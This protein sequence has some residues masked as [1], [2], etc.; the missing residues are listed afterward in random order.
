MSDYPDSVG[1]MWPVDAEG[2]D[3][4]HCTTIYLG[5]KDQLPSKEEILSS[6]QQV[7]WST[8]GEIPV[9][10]TERFG[11]GTDDSPYVDVA[12]LDD[13]GHL[14]TQRSLMLDRLDADLG[15]KDGSSFPEYQPH[16]TLGQE[17][18]EHPE[19]ASSYVL[20][21]PQLWYGDERIPLS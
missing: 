21:A 11:Q 7:P 4:P 5:D 12:K 9:A 13:P 16:V 19:A 1:I 14:L 17:G 10:S 18:T 15:V 2:I 6:L 20:G 3:D 8:P